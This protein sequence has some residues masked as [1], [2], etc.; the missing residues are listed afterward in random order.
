MLQKLA[1][2][3]VVL[4]IAV[5]CK[6]GEKKDTMVMDPVVSETKNEQR[7]EYLSQ[8]PKVPETPDILNAGDTGAAVYNICAERYEQSLAALK[9]QSDELEAKLIVTILSPEVGDAT[10]VSGQKGIPLINS[11]S[12][13]LGLDVYD[14]MKPL[15]AFVGQKITQMPLDGHWS[16]NGS[17]VVADL[18]QPIIGKYVAHRSTKTFA[19]NERPAVLGDLDPNQDVALDGGKNLPYQLITNKQ[20]FRMNTD[21]VFPKAKQ[22]ILLIGDS[23]LYSPFLDNSQIFTAL[24]Q[25]R[26][27]D[28]EIINAGVIGYTIDDQVSLI[29]ERAKYAEPDLI[30]LVTNPNDIG[31]FYFTQRNRMNRAKKAYDP[32]TT[33]LALY[34]QLYGSK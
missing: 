30:I 26:F 28:A 1:L 8:Y 24:L 19:E 14:C 32:T 34:Q 13:K 18:Y 29:A 7:E 25:Q 33:E 16:V 4:C 15:E 10:T 31:D 20:G 3:F 23:Q 21:L 6:D 5:S 2:P 12:K 11:I 9:Q 22:R 27:P 17:K